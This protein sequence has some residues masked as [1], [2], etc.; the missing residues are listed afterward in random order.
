MLLEM[1][2][3][4]DGEEKLFLEISPRLHLTIL[5]FLVDYISSSNMIHGI[6]D[7]RIAE[8]R[9]LESEIVRVFLSSLRRFDSE[10]RSNAK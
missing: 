3:E 2:I 8:A 7:V 4:E 1:K 10:F 9:K 6:V 5:L